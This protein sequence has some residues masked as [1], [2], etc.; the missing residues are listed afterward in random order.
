MSPA[1]TLPPTGIEAMDRL[2]DFWQ[3][4]RTDPVARARAGQTPHRII[5]RQNKAALR[6]FPARAGVAPAGVAPIF[7]S[8]PLINTWTIFDLLPGRS[9][10]EALTGAGIPVYLLD[11]GRPGPEDQPVTMADLVDDLL[12]RALDRAS[13]HARA[14]GGDGSLQA[15][16]YCVGGTFL[17][18]RLAHDPGPATRM[19]LLAAPI[20]F[21]ASGR[22]STWASPETFPLDDIIDGL[23]N[24]P[25]P[26]MRGSFQLLR[27]SGQVA[28]WKGLYERIDDPGF[29]EL[30]AAMEQWSEDGV[31]FPGEAYREYVRRCYFDNALITGGW[32]LGGRP[33]DLGAARIPADALAA[34]GDHICTPDAAFG[35][36]RAWGAPTRTRQLKG[37]HVGVCVGKALPAALIAWAKERAE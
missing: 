35:L 37:G 15:L 6:F 5:H 11:W 2:V 9:V 22:L 10:L 18:L 4:L 25:A 34:D 16:G 17:S 20:D 29:R 24:F 8:M 13:R 7:I 33:V 12:P 36:A 31:A 19:A 3:F 30:W 27:P 21:H 28:K 23:G 32:T 14:E 1:A 26:L